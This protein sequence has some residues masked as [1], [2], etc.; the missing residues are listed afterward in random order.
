[1][2]SIYPNIT[3]LYL[4][5]S[6]SHPS[7]IVR[8]LSFNK[9]ERLE[10]VVGFS[11]PPPFLTAVIDATPVGMYPH[12]LDWAVSGTPSANI[13]TFSLTGVDKNMAA[14]AVNSPLSHGRKLLELELSFNTRMRT[15]TVSPDSLASLY[16]CCTGH[17]TSSRFRAS[18]HP[19]AQTS[20]E[21]TVV[22][23]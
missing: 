10:Q 3:T 21:A 23:L 13:H 17:N 1:M 4:E 9:L 7:Q 18:P 14:F 6:A 12:L 2:T 19:T 20:S 16:P 11:L 22:Y 8:A 15:R 5:N